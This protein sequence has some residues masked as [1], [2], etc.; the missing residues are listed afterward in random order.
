MAF[1]PLSPELDINQVVE[2]TPNFEYAMRVTCDSISNQSLEDFEKL[3][4]Y[5]TVLSG[6]PLVIEGFQSYIDSQLFSTKWLGEKYNKSK[7]LL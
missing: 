1:E 3:V 7:L 2:N 6:K 4:L 5:Q